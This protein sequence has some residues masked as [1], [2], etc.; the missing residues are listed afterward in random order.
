MGIENMLWKLFYSL[1]PGPWAPDQHGFLTRRCCVCLLTV[2]FGQGSAERWPGGP[3]GCQ[4]YFPQ[5]LFCNT[6]LLPPKGAKVLLLA[7]GPWM[8]RTCNAQVT[9]LSNSQQDTCFKPWYV[10]FLWDSQHLSL[11]P[12]TVGTISP[13]S[14]SGSWEGNESVTLA[15]TPL[16][17]DPHI[18]LL[19]T[20]LYKILWSHG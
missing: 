13:N 17:L 18:L 6:F 9:A 5:S 16:L 10:F 4:T 1:G 19:E 8:Q 2:R 11:V 12:S 14:P 20:T 15:F 3:P 7:A